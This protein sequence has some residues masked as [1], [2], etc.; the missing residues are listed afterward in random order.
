MHFVTG[1]AFNGK[2]NWVKHY[3]QQEENRIYWI[4]AY[5]NDG[6][7]DTLEG[8]TEDIIVLEGIEQWVRSLLGQEGATD[9]RKRWR[10][11]L[12]KWRMWERDHKGKSVTII[13]SDITKG[14]VP[15]SA[16]EREWR[17]VTGRIFQ[18]T[19]SISNR[20]DIIWY[21]IHQTMKEGE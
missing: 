2:S 16:E 6:L 4:S 14:I 11:L 1:G 17:D 20:V 13:G 7:P 10:I 15:V 12:E 9:V 19:V 21:G 3:Y 5:Q 18:D 8:I